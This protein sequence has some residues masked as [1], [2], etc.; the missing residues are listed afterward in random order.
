MAISLLGF[1]VY[2]AS[3]FVGLMLLLNGI[4]S[5]SSMEHYQ[6]RLHEQVIEQEALLGQPTRRSEPQSALSSLDRMSH[7]SEEHDQ[8]AATGALLRDRDT[9]QNTAALMYP[10]N[11]EP[12]SPA[13]SSFGAGA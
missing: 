6:K 9:G 13:S 7:P 11:S 8:P 10:G 12:Q 3:A 2:I 4:L 5:D 1:F